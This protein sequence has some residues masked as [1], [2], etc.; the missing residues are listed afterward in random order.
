[1][2]TKESDGPDEVIPKEPLL[3]EDEILESH[4]RQKEASKEGLQ[5]AYDRLAARLQ[6]FLDAAPG[7]LRELEKYF[8]VAEAV[9]SK[10][11]PTRYIGDQET[12]GLCK[13][14]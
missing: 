6:V 2:K 10:V 13:S 3:P 12:A 14:D 11:E 7:E 1:M 4:K 9:V 8:P 5:A